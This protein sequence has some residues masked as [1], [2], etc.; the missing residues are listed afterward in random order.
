MSLLATKFRTTKF[1][2]SV[3]SVCIPN[4]PDENLP[5][6]LIYH[7]GKCIKQIFGTLNFSPHPSCDEVEW[8]LSQA[9]AVKSN[10][11]EDPRKKDVRAKGSK[12]FFSNEDNE[13]SGDEQDYHDDWY[14]CEDE[15]P[16]VVSKYQI[17]NMSSN[18]KKFESI[19]KVLVK[20]HHTFTLR[21]LS[22]QKLH[23]PMVN[24]CISYKHSIII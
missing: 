11:E 19:K 16:E 18:T 1:L 20:N 5:G 12:M 17:L 4:F 21:I 9:G 14:V 10:L 13:S 15:R 8:V 6:I 23:S 24:C 2:R 7:N 3:S 22:N